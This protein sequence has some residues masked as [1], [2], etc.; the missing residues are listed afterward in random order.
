[1]GGLNRGGDQRGAGGSALTS[2]SS[3]ADLDH[4]AQI[5]AALAGARDEAVGP[6]KAYLG[7]LMRRDGASR[8]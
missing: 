1:M 7:I 2:D 3:G 4:I 5:Y 6:W 8:S